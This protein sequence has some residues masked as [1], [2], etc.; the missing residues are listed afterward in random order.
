MSRLHNPQEVGCEPWRVCCRGK[1]I[2]A[3]PN[4]P[5]NLECL[6]GIA[7]D[8]RV[9][10]PSWRLM[11]YPVLH[12]NGAHFRVPVP[13]KSEEPKVLTFDRGIGISCLPFMCDLFPVKKGTSVRT[14]FMYE[15]DY[16][17]T[18]MYCTARKVRSC[19]KRNSKSRPISLNI[20]S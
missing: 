3:E 14:T 1:T 9:G 12:L 7:H 11:K 10:L 8:L 6:R 4:L 18:R 5:V 15:Y 19:T 2:V 20:H 17:R 13:V 16:A